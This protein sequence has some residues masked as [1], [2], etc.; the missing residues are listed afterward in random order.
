MNNPFERLQGLREQIGRTKE[1]AVSVNEA[2]AA[3]IGPKGGLDFTHERYVTT[4]DGY[5]ACLTIFGYPKTVGDYW[6]TLL[7][8]IEGTMCKLD[9]SCTNQAQ[10]KL[11]L[12]KALDEQQTRYRTA[13]NDGERLD[14]EQRY[15][16]TE[17]MYTELSAYGKVMKVLLARIYVT[18]PTLYELD[19]RVAKIQA[20]LAGSGFRVCICTNETKSDWRSLFL[21]YT[22]QQASPY[23][24]HGQEL[25]ARPLAAGLPFHF[26]SLNDPNG[27]YFGTTKT[28][29]AVFFDLFRKTEIR[30]SYDFI[31]VGKK[32][33]G[34]STTLKKLMLDRAI[35]GDLVRV[36]DKEGE[37]V[38]LTEWLGGTTISMDGNGKTLLNLLQILPDENPATAYN[39]H[40]AKVCTAWSCLRGGREEENELLLLKLMLRLLYRNFGFCDKEGNLLRDL[41]EV[42][43]EEFPIFSD[44]LL[45]VRYVIDHYGE[46][47]AEIQEE[48]GVRKEQIPLLTTIEL[49]LSDLCNTYG[50]LFD[51]HTSIPDFYKEPVVCFDMKHLAEMEETVYDAQL[52]NGIAICWDNCLEVGGKMKRLWQEKKIAW[53]EITRTLLLIDEAH[54]SINARKLSIVAALILML[55]EAGKLFVGVG[56]ASQSIRD[57]VPDQVGAEAVEMIRTLFD[58]TTYKFVFNQDSNLLPKLQEVFQNSFTQQ[59]LQEIPA[60]TRG[61]CILSIAGDRNLDMEIYASEEELRIFD[62]GA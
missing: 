55:R 35:R 31:A 8:G 57:F 49:Q 28:G 7:T 38:Q 12:R 15:W 42:T 14:A 56:L 53:E 34:K 62:G 40:I 59:E 41:N 11:N 24:R 39:K 10:V 19:Q 1:R 36:F 25:L 17:E 60:L 29:G 30:L 6:L 45:V 4:G 18:E 33:S 9:L 44:L 43:P 16:E 61:R 48:S 54:K 21:S 32:R 27:M 2:F 50:N 46:F 47:E 26:S 37:F 58:L 5:E 3:E 23:A 20:E 13:R 52:Y 22:Q 51:G